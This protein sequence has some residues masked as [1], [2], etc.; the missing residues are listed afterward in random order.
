M[1]A[2]RFGRQRFGQVLGQILMVG[3]L[4][5]CGNDGTQAPIAR[6]VLVARAAEAAGP[7]RGE[8]SAFAGE[9]R[10]REETALA[11]RVGGKVLRRSVDAG[12]RVR[13]G[14]VIA[15]LDPGDLRLQ[16]ESLQAQ[17]AAAD[18]QLVRARADHARLAAL[19]EDRLVSRSALDQQTAAL[20]AAEGQARAARAQRD[21]A[22][23]QAAYGQLRAPRDGVIASR[24]IEAGQVVAAGQPAFTLAAD[25][26]REVAFALPESRI[27]EFRVGQPVVIEPWSRR[28]ERLPGRIREIAPSADPQARTYAARASLDGEAGAAVDL[29]QSARVYIPGSAAAGLHLPLSALQRD[30]KG[31]AAVWVVD[32][33]TR[34]ARQV[35]VT[36]GSYGDDGVDVRSGLKPDD[37]VVLAGGHLLH[38]GAP[39][40]PVDRSNRPVQGGAVLNPSA[41]AR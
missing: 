32:P 5:A 26:G 30:G 13:A 12:D 39:V 3:I 28:G 19:A 31:A 36:T 27:R 25:S 4:A 1:A 23:N 7:A 24:Q 21:L 16:A 2:R 33:A 10:A 35:S 29:G 37:W 20:R 17:A 18:A 22:R 11:F 38:D 34:K 8:L 6:P 41:Q 40:Q 14:D 9:V 15:E